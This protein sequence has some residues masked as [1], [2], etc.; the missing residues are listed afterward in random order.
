LTKAYKW[1]KIGGLLSFIPIAMAVGPL[2][3]YFAAD[4]LEKKFNFPGF[5]SAIFIIIGFT[6]ST[7]ETVKIIRLALKTEK[8][9]D[10][11]HV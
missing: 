8:E 6:A 7:I 9:M 3:G 4:Y 11:K 2:A 10:G 1:I 5:T